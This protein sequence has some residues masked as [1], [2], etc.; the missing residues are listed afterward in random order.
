VAQKVPIFCSS[1][2][3]TKRRRADWLAPCH[4]NNPSCVLCSLTWGRMAIVSGDTLIDRLC[5]LKILPLA[6]K[7]NERAASPA[8]V[9]TDA[10]TARSSA[11]TGSRGSKPSAGIWKQH[12]RSHRHMPLLASTGRV[13]TRAVSHT[14]RS[15]EPCHV[16]YWN[17]T[18]CRPSPGAKPPSLFGLAWS[19][20]SAA[21][22]CLWRQLHAVRA[23]GMKQC[24]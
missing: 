18:A 1:H 15:L 4:T 5:K 13:A 7:L 16:A 24:Q 20:L 14:S 11:R 19:G 21:A 3:I 6:T 12:A 2:L 10:R 22:R 17:T 8:C 9:W 23:C